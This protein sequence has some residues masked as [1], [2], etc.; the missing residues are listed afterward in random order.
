[1]TASVSSSPSFWM[2]KIGFPFLRSRLS[3]ASTVW[4]HCGRNKY[5]KKTALRNKQRYDLKVRE[6]TLQ[7]GDRVLVKNVGIRGKHKIADW[8][9]KTICQ[10]VKQITDSPVYAVK[11]LTTDGPERNLHRDLLLPCGFLTPTNSSDEDNRMEGKEKITCSGESPTVPEDDDEQVCD[12]DGE[13]DFY[14]PQIIQYKTYPTITIVKDVPYIQG[15]EGSSCETT[16][17]EWYWIWAC[18]I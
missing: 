13:P 8:W 4:T 10:V 2:K 16:L 1:M 5:I 11:P 3:K 15:V 12:S 18:V 6:S 9:S 14:F 7:A 17:I